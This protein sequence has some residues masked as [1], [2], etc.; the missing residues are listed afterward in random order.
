MHLYSSKE[1][2]SPVPNIDATVSEDCTQL[3][4]DGSILADGRNGC[5]GVVKSQNGDWIS[6]FYY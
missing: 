4:V 1:A 2:Q 3:F 6:S 5:G